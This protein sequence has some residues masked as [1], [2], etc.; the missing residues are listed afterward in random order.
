MT[1]SRSLAILGF[2]GRSS[3][4]TTYHLAYK[5]ADRGEQVLVVDGTVDALVSESLLGIERLYEIWADEH[6]P[7][8]WEAPEADLPLRISEG[9][10]LLP[11][12]PRLK[13]W[14]KERDPF[15]RLGERIDR[16]ACE[17]QATWILAA[18]GIT[19]SPSDTEILAS[20][21]AAAIVAAPHPYSLRAMPVAAQAWKRTEGSGLAACGGPELLGYLVPLFRQKLFGHGDVHAACLRRLPETFRRSFDLPAPEVRM[22][23]Q[24]DPYCLGLVERPA[25]LYELAAEA[26]KPAFQLRSA[27]GA[28]ESL[29]Y[30]AFEADRIY[31]ELAAH[32]TRRYDTLVAP[33]GP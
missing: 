30:A 26:G 21:R 24:E 16:V 5:L 8:W 19:S 31:E 14:P 20:T 11:G 1:L 29:L 12:D 23:P 15:S 25:G 18:L 33:R 28:S 4:G 13:T 2:G 32:I 22:R 9:I 3:S 10:H 6:E 27:D 17:V 7:G